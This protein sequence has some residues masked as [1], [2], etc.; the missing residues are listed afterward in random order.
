M[1]N[2]I[3]KMYR[4]GNLL[5]FIYLGLGGL[6]FVIGLIVGIIGAATEH[7]DVAKAGWD[8]LGWG[9]YLTLGAILCLIFVIGKAEKQAADE[10]NKSVGPYVLGG[11]FGLIFTNPFYVI[12]AVF[13]IIVV[14]KENNAE[15][16]EEAKE[17]T[18]EIE[19]PK[20]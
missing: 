18:K 15:P 11:V 5:N 19:Q 9:I 7:P 20:E 8:L 2:N 3:P 14:S 6:F 4:F 17:E 10:N 16:K 1:K 12:A 13:G